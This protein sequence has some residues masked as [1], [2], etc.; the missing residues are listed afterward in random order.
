[1]R[2][3][4][5]ASDEK[6]KLIGKL[7]KIKVIQIVSKILMDKIVLSSVNAFHMLDIQRGASNSKLPLLT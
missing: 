1:M 5:L 7:L 6:E 2:K 4:E 3:S